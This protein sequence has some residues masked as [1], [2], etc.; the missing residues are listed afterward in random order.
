MVHATSFIVLHFSPP[1]ATTTAPNARRSA[2][3]QVLLHLSTHCAIDHSL[4][5]ILLL[6]HINM[7]P[8]EFH[9][10]IDTRGD[11]I[12]YKFDPEVA[13]NPDPAWP[14][15]SAISVYHHYVLKKHCT[16][17]FHSDLLPMELVIERW[18]HDKQSFQPVVGMVMYKENM[19]AEDGFGALLTM[20]YMWKGWNHGK[21]YRRGWAKLQ[22]CGLD[23]LSR[24][25]VVSQDKGKD[26]ASIEPFPRAN[27]V[28]LVEERKRRD[29]KDLEESET[30][31][32]T[33]ES[34]TADNAEVRNQT[35]STNSDIADVP[36]PE[37]APEHRTNE[38]EHGYDRVIEY[39]KQGRDRTAPKR[40]KNNRTGNNNNMKKMEVDYRLKQEYWPGLLQV[41]HVPISANTVLTAWDIDIHRDNHLSGIQSLLC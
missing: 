23:R 17:N 18:R 38:L 21:G 3:H 16:I 29:S 12:I 2:A 26:S 7:A 4:V 6:Q 32:A 33:K 19:P 22:I 9:R 20:Q 28:T 41:S 34:D 37:F 27:L 31:H 11:S 8:V 36:L 5:R 1:A 40:S 14:N 10:Y 39:F 30:R 24:A 35:Q 25:T 13:R 15:D